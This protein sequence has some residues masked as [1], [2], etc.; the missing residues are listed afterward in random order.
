MKCGHTCGIDRHKR[1]ADRTLLFEYMSLCLLQV[2]C[3]QETDGGG[4]IVFQRRKDG[5]VDFYLDWADYKIGFGNVLEEFWLGL[6]YLH[7]LT[8]SGHHELRIDMKD[9]EQNTSYSMYN[10]F[11]V[12][13]ESEKYVLT[14]S[15]YSG[16]AGDALWRHQNGRPFSTKD[17]DVHSCAQ[18]YK[19]GWWYGSCHN[20]N[21]NG[22]YLGGEHK[23]Y[24][25]GINWYQWKGFHYS[26]KFVETKFREIITQ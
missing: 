14:A 13:S 24:A 20:A 25:D 15:G 5:S 11:K 3:D 26:L 23:S 2:Y 1:Q 18:T 12:G 4:W 7:D 9:F 19:G 10:T 17:A 16:D 21:L 8:A 6:D 22:P